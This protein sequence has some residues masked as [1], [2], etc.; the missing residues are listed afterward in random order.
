[1]NLMML[2]EMASSGFGDRV[3]L[4]SR[5]GSGLTY[6]ELFDRAGAAA[7]YFEGAGIDRVSLVDVSSPALPIALF[8]AAWAG[9]PFAPL[10]YRLTADELRRLAAEVAPTVT[11]C[12]DH[13]QPKLW[14]VGGVQAV[15]RDEF[16]EEVAGAGVPAPEW[17]MDPD[18]IAILLY[19]SGTTGAP[20]AA[21]LRH[22][23]LVSYI[24]A[25]VEFMGADEDEATLISVPPYHVAG[26]AAILSAVYAGR[27]IVQL[28]NFDA[29]DWV[30]VAVREGITHAMVVPTML[31]RI[32]DHLEA[33][34][35]GTIP[36]LRTISYGGGKMPQPVIEK[37]LDLLPHTAFVNAYGLTETSSTICILGPEEHRAAQASTEPAARRRL[38]SVG[39]PLPSIELSIR[40]EDG[41]EVAPGNRGE[42]WVRGEQVSGEYLGRGSQVNTEG[43]FPTKDGGYVDDEGY[44]FL[45][46][47]VDDII[48]RGGENISPGEIEEVLLAHPAVSEAAAIG[49]PSRQWGE[50]VAAVVVLSSGTSTSAEVL[51][52]WVTQHLRSSRAP[53]HIEFRSELPYNDMGKLLRRVLKSELAARGDTE[54]DT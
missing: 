23:H 37:A 1:M 28:P 38:T 2:L 48:I 36:T 34:G 31:A 26:M 25:S 16:L 9:K 40:D 24:L 39:K 8:G 3:A 45:E 6:Q 50:A 53:E 49:I 47:R 43:W 32:V 19:T 33:S 52:D 17:S 42:I 21:V 29:A 51:R 5:D 41:R 12:D 13:A 46:G 22:K 18:E 54:S 30:N 10:N 44:L 7:A 14:N 35:I 4:G 20:K 15:R 27:R 11:I